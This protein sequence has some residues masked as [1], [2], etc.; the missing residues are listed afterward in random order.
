MDHLARPV[1]GVGV[2]LRRDDGRVAIGHRVTAGE[3]PSWSF[4][5]GHLEGAEAP[6][7]TALRELAEET[8]VVATTGTL[9]AVCV[10]TAGSGVTF[11]VHVP[12]PAGAELA[13][14]EPHAVDA[15]T[16]ADP[17]DLPEPL[18]AHTAAVRHAWRSP[19]VQLA[20]WDLHAVAGGVA[21]DR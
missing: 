1:S 6:V 10:R 7:R 15:W 4:P 20:G 18:F 3:T 11:A 9:F 17:D 13:V 2:V 12:A 21:L 16:W 14:T 8:G 19:G 5:G